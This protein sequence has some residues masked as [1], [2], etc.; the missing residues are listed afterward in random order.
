MKHKTLVII[1]LILIGLG[2]GHS[3]LVLLSLAAILWYA[4]KGF[5]WFMLE[6][7]DASNK[8][9]K[10]RKQPRSSRGSWR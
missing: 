2:S 3:A 5:I 6:L 7:D 8:M 1:A 10:Y 9:G 4:V